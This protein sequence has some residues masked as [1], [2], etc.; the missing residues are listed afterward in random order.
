MAGSVV[1]A[2]RQA[3]VA[4]LVARPGLSGVQVTYSWPGDDVAQRE[5][6]F[7]GRSQAEHAQAS[8]RSGRRFR[9]EAATFDV[10]I[11]VESLNQ[12][13]EQTEQRAVALGLE[14]EE[15]VADNKYLGGVAGLNWA[16]VS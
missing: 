14:V 3:L 11:Q 15:C 2:A 10:L 12:T 7:T 8:L 13:I 1:V 6:V 9:N 16:V 4:L 5:R